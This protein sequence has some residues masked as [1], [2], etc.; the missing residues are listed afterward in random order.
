MFD[1][2]VYTEGPKIGSVQVCYLS[3]PKKRPTTFDKQGE[4]F[5]PSQQQTVVTLEGVCAIGKT[6]LLKQIGGALTDLQEGRD[7]PYR[8]FYGC[9]EDLCFIKN[10]HRNKQFNTAKSVNGVIFVDRS[11]WL[12]ASV[13]YGYHKGWLFLYEGYLADYLK[14][15]I[16]GIRKELQIV[17][18]DKTLSNEELFKRMQERGG[19]DKNLSAEYVSTTR[20]LFK[21][22]ADHYEIP[23]RS[24]KEIL[25]I[26]ENYAK[27]TFDFSI[28]SLA[29]VPQ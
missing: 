10:D 8:A 16:G 14:Y 15:T 22:V 17:V 6:T 25:N 18:D 9:T 2:F 29:W 1:E 24:P 19:I 13:Y 11:S 3:D 12:S 5:T 7:G 4:L 21:L 20:E 28:E 27:N 26:Y 23:V